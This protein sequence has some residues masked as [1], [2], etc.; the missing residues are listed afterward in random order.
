MT[1]GVPAIAPS[2]AS[3]P[4]PGRR[5]AGK[6]V[7][8]RVIGRGGMGT[9][10]EARHERLGQRVAIKVLGAALRDHPDLVKRFER[11]ARAAGS[12]TSPHAAR[13]LDIDTTADGMPFM[14]MELLSGRDLAR[15]VA[16]SGPQPIALAARWVIEASDAIGEAHRLGIIHRD[17]KPSN[18]FLCDDGTIKVLDFGIA[19][20]V[21]AKEEA[22]TAGI[23]PLGTPQYMSPEQVRCT[24]DLDARTDVWSLGVTL[25]ELVTGRPPYDHEIA[26][27]CIAA[28]VIDPVPHPRSLRPELPDD[29]AGVVMHALEKDRDLRFQSVEELVVALEPFAEPS[30]A[31]RGSRR[32]ASN[33]VR[34]SWGVASNERETREAR[35]T[36]EALC[37]DRRAR[38]TLDRDRSSSERTRFA[39]RARRLR[40]GLAVAT[41]A[42][43]GLV[44]LIMTPRR[45]RTGEDAPT[46]AAAA[47]TAS[48]AQVVARAA[49]SVSPAEPS[50]EAQSVAPEAA[51][52]PAPNATVHHLP[53]RS[54]PR[55]RP[56]ARPAKPV[57]TRPPSDG[58]GK[59]RVVVGGDRLVHGGISSPGF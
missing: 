26:Q 50:G 1:G 21:A 6:Y 11:E 51:K 57:V 34:I 40:S 28:I 14:V 55:P 49:S 52:E 48:R 10:F 45:A 13:V 3:R 46:V 30:P 29:F 37:R 32:D 27:A 43:L 41:A 58:A 36:V 38:R 47:V 56:A 19:K 20:R 53:P 9:V 33:D 12:L 8:E 54:V 4:E 16:E 2:H 17:I 23:A 7:V 22:L 42:T 15:L 44:A 59:A 24:K 5:F 35:D 31:R 39:S 25:Y 18:L